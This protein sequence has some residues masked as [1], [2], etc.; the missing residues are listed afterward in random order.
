MVSANTPHATSNAC[1]IQMDK[2]LNLKFLQH[3]G[4]LQDL[5]STGDVELINVRDPHSS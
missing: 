4:L 5:V 2:V 3:E 1:V